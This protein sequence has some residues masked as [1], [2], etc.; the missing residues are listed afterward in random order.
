[1]KKIIFLLFLGASFIA[2]KDEKKADAAKEEVKEVKKETANVSDGIFNANVET[3]KLNWEGSK[4]TGTHNG[5]VAIKEGNLV[6]KEGKLSAGTFTFD[7]TAITV[8]DIPAEEKGNAKLVGHLK[9]ADFFDVEN[10][11]T[12]TFAIT[13]VVEG[14]SM[15][16]KGDLTIKGITKNIS[17]PVSFSSDANGVSLKGAPFKIN[18]TLFDIKYKSKS[19][20]ENLKDKFIDDEFE[21]SFEVNASK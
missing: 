4:P 14:E 20:F 6:V 3:S 5:V 21:I 8:L 11:P 18:R 15:V 17:F 19:F 16:V 10:N 1:M 9:S 12:A 7:M 13:E 2:C